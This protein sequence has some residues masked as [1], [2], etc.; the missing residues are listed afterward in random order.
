MKFTYYFRT[1]E[2]YHG[3]YSIESINEWEAFRSFIKYLQ[4][5]DYEVLDFDCEEEALY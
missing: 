5:N 4:E 1:S 3:S 2:K